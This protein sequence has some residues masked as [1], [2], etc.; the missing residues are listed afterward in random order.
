MTEEA[1]GEYRCQAYNRMGSSGEVTVLSL[2]LSL[3]SFAR[4]H[5]LII[6][7]DVWEIFYYSFEKFPPGLAVIFS[8]QV[9]QIQ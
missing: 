1:V 7:F 8:H 9:N 2:S 5:I 4:Q 3:S 6:L